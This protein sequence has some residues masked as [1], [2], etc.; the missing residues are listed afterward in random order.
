MRSSSFVFR[1]AR[2]HVVTVLGFT[3]PIPHPPTKATTAK[4]VTWIDWL[5]ACRVLREGLLNVSL[6]ACPSRDKVLAALH[7]GKV[8]A[9]TSVI[10]CYHTLCIHD[11]APQFN[12]ILPKSSMSDVLAPRAART[13]SDAVATS[14]LIPAPCSPATI[15]LSPSSPTLSQTP[16]PP[17]APS[18]CQATQPTRLGE[19]VRSP[20]R[21]RRSTSWS[22][23]SI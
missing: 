23:P 21:R 19:K 20:L 6:G 9:F 8:R 16:S 10:A 3:V 12:P 18:N 15:D 1:T 11:K 14:S 2:Q 5:R 17:S 22:L 4:L 13:S 7:L